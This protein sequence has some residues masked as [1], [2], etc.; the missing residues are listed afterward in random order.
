MFGTNALP[1][2]SPSPFAHE[3]RPLRL[4]SEIA[5]PQPQGPC[6]FILLHPTQQNQRCSCQSFHHNRAAP[7]NICDCGHQACYHLPSSS[8]QDQPRHHETI[9]LATEHALLE[10][11]KRLEEVIQSE[12]EI[13]E[14]EMSRQKQSS[15]REVRILREALAPFYKSEQEMRRKLVEL[16][17]RVEGNYDEQV[18]LKER[19]VAVDDSNMQVEKR[20]EELEGRGKRRRVSRQVGGEESI[21]NGVAGDMRRVS[22]LDDRSVQSSSSRALSPNSN[23]GQPHE[24]EEPRS[25]GILNLVEAPRPMQFP[26]PA[27]LTKR[28]SGERNE[29]RSSGFLALDLAERLGNRKVQ[30]IHPRD[31]TQARALAFAAAQRHSPPDYAQS[32]P[33]QP[34][35]R[36]S[37]SFPL[38]PPYTSG[39]PRAVMQL[40][41]L[42]MSPRKRKHLTDHMALDVLADVSVASPLIH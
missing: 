29:P 23:F 35:N 38:P 26:N 31:M 12:R 18:R 9:A 7:G 21:P 32:D 36:R 5:R 27:S 10:R 37:P 17:D 28:P 13:R 41:S 3:H 30:A 24:L 16:E 20:I 4:T 6:H 14:T 8:T 39:M 1:L 11:I 19:V 42:Q 22:N 33:D 2:P 40:S 15:E 34:M 25:S